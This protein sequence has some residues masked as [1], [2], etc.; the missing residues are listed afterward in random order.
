MIRVSITFKLFSFITIAFIVTTLSVLFL[1]TN[2]LNDIIYKSQS[3]VYSEK[4][5]AIL[6][7]LD[8]KVQRLRLTGN[9][10]AYEEDFKKSAVQT[11]REIYYRPASQMIYPMILDLDGKIVIHPEF[12]G[13]DMSISN[14]D[15]IKKSLT[16]KE[17]EFRYTREGGKEN[18]FIF[19]YFKE[20]DWLIGY[21]LP[22][23][24]KY[25][26]ARQFRN[27]LI[28]IMGAITFL[29]LFVLAVIIA[30]FTKPI[31]RLTKISAEMHIK[32][33]IGHFSGNFNQLFD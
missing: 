18:W 21:T 7:T 20:W 26:D 32:I 12:P 28:I 33:S 4:L 13:G 27:G 29:V 3:A 31:I 8:R 22:L 2:Q 10:E 23:D 9:V 24:I 6:G 14:S 1:A 16:L 19:R 30:R 15:Y 11:L 5:E 17:G 25:A